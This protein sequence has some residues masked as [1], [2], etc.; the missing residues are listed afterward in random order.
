MLLSLTFIGSSEVSDTISKHA[1]VESAYNF[2]VSKAKS[3]RT[4]KQTFIIYMKTANI[5]MTSSFIE[6]NQMKRWII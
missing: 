2:V 1:H 5:L 6:T 3:Q 4:G